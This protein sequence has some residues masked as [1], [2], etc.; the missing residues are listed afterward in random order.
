MWQLESHDLTNTVEQTWGGAI[1]MV[2]DTYAH[3]G[4][5]T[6]RY[7]HCSGLCEWHV[8]LKWS[9]HEWIDCTFCMVQSKERGTG[10][11]PLTRF[12]CSCCS[13]WSAVR[14]AC[15]CCV[16]ECALA[17]E[18]YI[19]KTNVGVDKECMGRHL[20]CCAACGLPVMCN[21]CLI[22]NAILFVWQ[23]T[24]LHGTKNSLY[25]TECHTYVCAQVHV[26]SQFN[27]IKD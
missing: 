19:W 15:H 10:V 16:D 26:M 1:L 2:D 17:W 27:T 25:N 4:R 22:D 5:L 18:A 12:W 7:M 21:T 8:L 13:E 23:A 20:H 6:H 24:E 11:P 3:A 9:V 14:Y